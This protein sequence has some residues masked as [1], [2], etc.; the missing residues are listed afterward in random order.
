MQ[1]RVPKE[2]VNAGYSNDF[3]AAI[4]LACFAI[5]NF[6]RRAWL[7]ANTTLPAVFM[8]EGDLHLPEEAYG[9]YMEGLRFDGFER[10]D[11]RCMNPSQEREWSEGER[12]KTAGRMWRVY[13][14][15]RNEEDAR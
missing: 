7:R 11:V 9:P 8:E 15:I 12:K 6:C 3:Q 2:G 1:F 4:P 13:Q 10:R 14:Q 5:H